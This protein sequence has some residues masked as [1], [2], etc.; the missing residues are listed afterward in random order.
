M[1]VEREMS[2]DD[3][4]KLTQSLDKRVSIQYIY[5]KP[6]VTKRN[7]FDLHDF[8]LLLESRTQI[9]GWNDNQ[10]FYKIYQ[11]KNTHEIKGVIQTKNQ[12]YIIDLGSPNDPSSEIS[13]ILKA[14]N[15]MPFH[16]GFTRRNLIESL[17][18]NIARGNKL[19]VALD[20]LKH[21]KIIEQLNRRVLESGSIMYRRTLH[22]TSIIDKGTK[23]S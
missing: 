3:L 20:Y 23:I 1:T 9:K 2:L 11:N 14:V 18:S 8:D 4:I 17:P 21:V 6:I 13:T 5:N 16:E 19:K 12:I 7:K 15:S 10:S 22:Q